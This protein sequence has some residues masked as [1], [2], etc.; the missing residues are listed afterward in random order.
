M[1]GTPKDVNIDEVIIA[2]EGV[3]GVR[4][5]HDLHVWSI[6]S[7]RNALSAHVVVEDGTSFK[8]SQDIL[9]KIES[10]LADQK[11]GHVTVQ[12]ENRE[13]SH[14]ESVIHQKEGEAQEHKQY[15]P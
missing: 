9:V 5:I 13:H 1:E 12:L 8:E 11:I 3:S 10:V 14:T 15:K 7:G 6:T 2:V 4:N